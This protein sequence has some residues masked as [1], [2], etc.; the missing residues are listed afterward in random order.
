MNVPESLSRV[1]DFDPA[2]I[3]YQ[4]SAGEP[5]PTRSEE[6]LR[7][8]AAYYDTELEWHPSGFMAVM[9]RGEDGFPTRIN[10]W[11]SQG[12]L[13]ATDFIGTVLV[14]DRS[15]AIFDAAGADP[16]LSKQAPLFTNEY[17][18]DSLGRLIEASQIVTQ[19]DLTTRYVFRCTLFNYDEDGACTPHALDMSDHHTFEA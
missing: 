15:G 10:V 14:D 5:T 9:Q 11:D 3:T 1:N 12:R 19:N 4:P 8:G 18:Y 6:Q 17:H 2:H 13:I 16:A 7:V